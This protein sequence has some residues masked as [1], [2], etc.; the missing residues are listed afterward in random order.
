MDPLQQFY[1]NVGMR[2]TV[3]GFILDELKKKAIEAVMNKQSTAGIAEANRAVEA[4]FLAMDRMFKV[5]RKRGVD[6]SR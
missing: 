2:E 5:A 3:K 1:E 4:S 6:S